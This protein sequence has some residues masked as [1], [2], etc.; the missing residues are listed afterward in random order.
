MRIF[1]TDPTIEIAAMSGSV[2]VIVHPARSWFLLIGEIA[3]MALWLFLTWRYWNV[4]SL[5]FRVLSAFLL[6]SGGAGLLFQLT[7]TEIIEIDASRLSVLRE[8]HGWERKREYNITE[9]RE[10]QWYTDRDSSGLRCKRGWSTVTFGEQLTEEQAL[11]IM[12]ALQEHLPAVAQQLCSYPGG[13]DH[14]LTL[15]LTK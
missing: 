2:R 3:G 4:L 8:S 13:R 1:A 7:G 10:L 5:Q 15:G 12:T 6:A 14:F 9:C 11:E